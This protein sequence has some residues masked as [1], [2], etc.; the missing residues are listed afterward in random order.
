MLGKQLAPASV[1]PVRRR[2]AM[3]PVAFSQVS[4]ILNGYAQRGMFRGFA[5]LPRTETQQTFNLLWHYNRQ[6]PFVLNVVGKT[7][8]FRGL[9]S[10]IPA[11]STMAAD[12]R[13]FLKP[14]ST[15]QVP[16]HRRVDANAGRLK[17]RI[18]DGAL[19]LLIEVADTQYAYCTRKLVHLAHEIFMVFL[20]DGPYFE[21]RVENLGLDPDASWP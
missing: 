11:G 16:A 7:V 21:Y 2:M 5:A 1:R 17:T 19:T 14:F 20:W 9:L 4:E 6:Y 8:A 10:G 3:A 15:A 12:L 18:K 13:N